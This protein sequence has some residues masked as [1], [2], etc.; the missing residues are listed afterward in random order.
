[1][2]KI[3]FEFSKASY[4]NGFHVYE[5]GDGNIGDVMQE[6]NNKWT[7]TLNIEEFDTKEE[8]AESLWIYF[9]TNRDFPPEYY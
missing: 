5:V 6:E 4:Q 2:R 1:M 7:H 8:A 9:C 3:I